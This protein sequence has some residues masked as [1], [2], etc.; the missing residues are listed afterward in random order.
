MFLFCICFLFVLGCD[1]VN[2]FVACRGF[3]VYC[4]GEIVCFLTFARALGYGL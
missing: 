3:R 4:C 1:Y 2:M